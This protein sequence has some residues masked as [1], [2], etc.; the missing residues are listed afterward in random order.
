[1]LVGMR[2]AGVGI[3]WRLERTLRLE[4][5]GAASLSRVVIC[6]GQRLRG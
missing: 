3:P 4:P 6:E 5:F 1:M 2:P